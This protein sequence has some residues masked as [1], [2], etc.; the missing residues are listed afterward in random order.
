MRLLY[1]LRPLT[2]G[3]RVAIGLAVAVLASLRRVARPTQPGDRRH[4]LTSAVVAR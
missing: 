4:A 3:D 2:R 1:R